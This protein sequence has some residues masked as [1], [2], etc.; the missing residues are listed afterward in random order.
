MKR[1]AALV[2]AFIFC[3]YGLPILVYG[4]GLK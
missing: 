1:E 2:L 4:L 3:L